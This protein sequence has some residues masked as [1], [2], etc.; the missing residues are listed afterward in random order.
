MTKYLFIL[1]LVALGFHLHAQDLNALSF[2]G[3]EVRNAQ[4]PRH[5]LVFLHTDWCRFCAAMKQTT[6]KDEEVIKLLN[7]RMYFVS[8]DGESKEEVVFLGRSFKY[9]PSGAKTGIH[10]LAEQLGRVDG[11]V[12]YPTVVILDPDYQIVFQHNAFLDAEQLAQIVRAVPQ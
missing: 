7:E 9:T 12:A 3:L 4:A 5:T 10:Q 8:F 11:Q 6:F 1:S 2:P